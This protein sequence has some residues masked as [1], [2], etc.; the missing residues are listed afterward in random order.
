MI[1]DEDEDDEE[2]NAAY[3]HYEVLSLSLTHSRSVFVSHR[4]SRLATVTRKMLHI[5]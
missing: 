2:G 3:D 1:R 5:P 4:V